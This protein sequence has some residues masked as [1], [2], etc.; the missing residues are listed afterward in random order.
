MAKWSHLRMSVNY[1]SHAI[2]IFPAKCINLLGT[3]ALYEKHKEI[4]TKESILKI[5]VLPG[6][7]SAVEEI[8]LNYLEDNNWEAYAHSQD[9]ESDTTAF[10]KLES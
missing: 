2:F 9:H 4:S 6:Q 3:L 10:K 1:S 5:K 7:E 8:V